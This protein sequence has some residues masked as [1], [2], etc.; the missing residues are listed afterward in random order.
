MLDYDSEVFIWVGK[1]VPRETLVKI[2]KQGVRAIKAVSCKGRHR[3]DNITV[4][5][6][7]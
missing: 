7:H 4:S 6:T 1:D 5:I 3:L 2:P